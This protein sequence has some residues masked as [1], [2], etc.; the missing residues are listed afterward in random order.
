V[1]SRYQVALSGVVLIVVTIV[2]P[3]GISGAVAGLRHRIDE[4]RRTTT[5]E[6]AP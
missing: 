3:D 6:V 5:A 2:Q 4:R 1:G